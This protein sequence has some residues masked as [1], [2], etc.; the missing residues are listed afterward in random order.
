MGTRAQARAATG[1][2]RGALRLARSLAALDQR[3]LTRGVSATARRTVQLGG[4]TATGD[5]AL[6]RLVT[7][8]GVTAR[9]GGRVVRRTSSPGQLHQYYLQLVGAVLVVLAVVSV[10]V[11]VESSR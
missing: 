2:G 7:Q 6:A 11:L 5:V 4:S 9:S 3:V 8:V 1:L 10:V